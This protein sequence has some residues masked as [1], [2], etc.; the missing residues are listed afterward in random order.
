[1]CRRKMLIGTVMIGIGFAL[2]LSMVVPK[3]FWTIVVGGIL[4]A[5]GYLVAC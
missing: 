2:L 4:I 1:M 3:S 5:I